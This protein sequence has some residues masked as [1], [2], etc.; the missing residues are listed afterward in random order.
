MKKGIIITSVLAVVAALTVAAVK[1][2]EA[3]LVADIISDESYQDDLS[4]EVRKEY[5]GLLTFLHD[6]FKDHW[7]EFD[8]SDRD[9]SDVWGYCSEYVS[10]SEH[11]IDGNGI[12]ELILA[13]SFDD[14]NYLIYDIFT[15]NEES[16]TLVHLAK[17]GERDTFQVNGDGVIIESGSNSAYDSFQRGF[18]IEDCRLTE[19]RGNA[20][21]DDMLKIDFKRIQE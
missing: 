11:D 14:W 6:G 19:I 20:W 15:F 10:Y 5:E 17:G 8:P 2:H 21:H 7:E 3:Y 1:L 12:P 16:G 4:A 9:L 13:D 18:I